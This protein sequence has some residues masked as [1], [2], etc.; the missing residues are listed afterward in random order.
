MRRVRL[1]VVGKSQVIA[2]AA[3]ELTRYLKQ[4]DPQLYVDVL[5]VPEGTDVHSSELPYT[6]TIYLAKDENLA[7]CLKEGQNPE[8]D[9]VIAIAIKGKSGYITGTN[10]R[11]VLIG[12]YRL[13]KELGCAFLRPGKEGERIPQKAI[14]SIDVTVQEAASYRHRGVCIE[15]ADAYENLYDTIDF[16]PKAGMNEYF[17]QFLVPGTFFERW[18]HHLNNPYLPKENLNHAEIVA[19]TEQLEEEIGLRGIRYHKT[20]HGWTCEPFGLEGTT[21]D[22]E[23][24]YEV[25]E[26]TRTYLAEVN[27]KRELWGNVPLNTNLCYS[28]P[29]VRD[30][31]TSAITNYCKEN[32][33]VSCLHFWLADG[34]N[35][36]CECPECQKKRPSDWYV[37]MLNEL[38][39]KM[40]AAKLDTKVVFLIYVD[41]L[42][43]PVE[44]ELK[45]P[46]RFI[47]MF[48][49][50]TRTYGTSY[51][52]CLEYKEELPDYER[53]HLT[54]PRS[55]EQN[56]EHLRRWQAKFK[57]DSFDYDYHL[58]WA[59]VMDPG[60]EKCA[61]G[62]FQDMKDLHT[63]GIEGMMSCQVQRSF[64]PT[65]LPFTEMAAA[66][67]DETCDFDEVADAYYA[68]A[69][70]EDG[71]QVRA[72]LQKLS[73]LFLM[74][75][76]PARSGGTANGPFCQDYV[77][78]REAVEGIQPLIEKNLAQDGPCKEEWKMLQLHSAITSSTARCLELR[79]KG[80]LEESRKV[81][82]Q[83]AELIARNEAAVQKALD[84]NNTIN[85]LKGN[86]IKKD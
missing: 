85:V 65:A 22:T 54:M 59:H 35:N 21:W 49:P 17:I 58:M 12:V 41:L 62:L 53:N 60:Y 39:E 2:F 64:F 7:S 27:G 19:M 69:Y 31:M 28:N 5:K 70:G 46:D 1:G 63:I 56:L 30:T 29:E 20:G 43:E 14:E 42:W 74:Y 33:Q 36:H 48:A 84:A 80:E 82:E 37:Q 78:V 73:E 50:I 11:S 13:L 61:K 71:A 38:D 25:S 72:Y 15:G 45:N 44:T 76:A 81:A 32:P 8:E 23:R 6:E 83:L 18:Y 3:K 47:L 68:A 4:M 86:L 24:T 57:G 67:W 66:L 52:K 55:L 34:S 9:D 16:L 77:A 79:E 51:G 40:T 10:D 26:K 75:D